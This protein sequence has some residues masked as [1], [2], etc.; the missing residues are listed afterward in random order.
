MKNI[1]LLIKI[2]LKLSNLK[3]KFKTNKSEKF[4]SQFK[5]TDKVYWSLHLYLGQTLLIPKYL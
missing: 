2:N 4:I 1:K 3:L 5:N